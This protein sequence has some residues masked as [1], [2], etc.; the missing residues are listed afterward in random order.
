MNISLNQTVTIIVNIKIRVES[1]NKYSDLILSKK[2]QLF[3]D[4]LFLYS[5]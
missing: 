4:W 2:S 1:I 5:N 3:Y